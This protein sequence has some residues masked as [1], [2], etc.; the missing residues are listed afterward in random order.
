M[1]TLTRLYLIII[2][3]VTGFFLLGCAAPLK[4]END[5]VPYLERFLTDAAKYNQSYPTN[6]LMLQFGELKYPVVGNC[7]S[8]TNGERIVTIDK[9][10]WAL[11][12]DGLREELVYHE[13]G[14][15]L[16]GRGHVE[17]VLSIMNSVL[18]T[19]SEYLSEHQYMLDELFGAL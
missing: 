10:Y 1:C 11:A 17:N 12:G 4:K 13:L 7:A 5:L 9:N 6:T 2:F 18:N 8:Y 14:H 16:L 3:I 15:C 19:E